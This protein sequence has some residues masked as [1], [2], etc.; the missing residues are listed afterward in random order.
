MRRLGE[1]WIED[2]QKNHADD[3][4]KNRQQCAHAGII[5]KFIAT[6]PENQNIRLVT[7]WS[8]ETRC[9]TN[10]YR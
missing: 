9:G 2:W 6:G 8:Q 10:H 5:E 1:K 3:E 4:Q 7:N